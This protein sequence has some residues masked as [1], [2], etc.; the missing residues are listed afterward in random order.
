MVTALDEP[1][2]VERAVDVGTNDFLTKPINKAELLLR[3]RA[4][5]AHPDPI[6]Y[7]N[8]VQNPKQ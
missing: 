3:I 7:I 8:A 2:D 1:A 5:L 4:M 6:D